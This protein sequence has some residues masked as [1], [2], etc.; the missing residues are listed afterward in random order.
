MAQEKVNIIVSAEDRSKGA[1]DKLNLNLKSIGNA[2]MIV[3][4]AFTASSALI[5]N[6]VLKQAAAFQQTEISFTQLLGSAEAAQVF[7]KKMATFAATTPFTLQGIQQNVQSLIAMGISAENSLPLLRSIGDVAA[8]LGRGEAG[9][10]AIT[11]ALGQ[12]QTA[13]KINAQDMNQL[14]AVGVPAWAILADAMGKPV[15][16]I[17]K[18]TETTNVSSSIMI[19][20]FGNMTGPLEKFQGLMEKQSKTWNGLMSTFKDSASILAMQIGTP[21][22]KV[23]TPAFE[24]LVGVIT[25]AITAIDGA[26]GLTAVLAKHRGIVIAVTG[27]I[28][29]MLVAALTAA[30]VAFVL[31]FP[32]VAL[33]TAG[34]IAIGIQAGLLIFA[35]AKLTS[36]I[37]AHIPGGIGGVFSKVWRSVVQGAEGMVNGLIEKFNTFVGFI[38]NVFHLKVKGIDWRADFSGLEDVG[39][40]VD[41]VKQKIT[42]FVSGALE[43]GSSVVGAWTDLTDETGALGDKMG[44]LEKKFS[45]ASEKMISTAKDLGQGISDALEDSNKKIFEIQNKLRD[46]TIQKI[47]DTA[48]K[49]KS[50]AQAYVDEQDEASKL[51][52]EISD[53]ESEH[54]N[55]LAREDDVLR[56]IQLQKKFNEEQDARQEKLTLLEEDL[57]AHSNLE[58]VFAQEIT[59]IRERQNKTSLQLA[60]DDFQKNIFIIGQKFEAEKL[61]LDAELAAEF[62]TRQKILGIQTQASKLAS[63]LVLSGEKLT[64]ESINRQIDAYNALAQAIQNARSGRTSSKFGL[65]LTTQAMEALAKTEAPVLSA[66][67]TPATSSQTTIVNV[68]GNTLLDSQAAEKIGD[69]IVDRFRMHAIV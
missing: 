54:R 29:T 64:I 20:A 63:D 43:A 26:G 24:I 1:F 10:D 25:K 21:I 23:I 28:G 15:A 2:A 41:G 38:N 35:L 13:T 5:G 58:S 60:L 31:I 16:E 51:A 61:A 36:W 18:L 42:G 57:R 62:E 19:N 11:R 17:K 50:L 3:G 66:P 55:A 53:A 65:E 59:D 12:M 45:D 40:I 46:L 56:R 14:I 34:I 4:A 47:E 32:E 69:V 52:K 9:V 49:Q 39:N 6:F 68:T 30:L 7:M 44:E 8:G 48:E 27:A 22:L 37:N 33:V 67:T